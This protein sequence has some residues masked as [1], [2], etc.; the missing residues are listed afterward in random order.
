MLLTHPLP[1]TRISEARARAGSYGAR[2]L[3]PSLDFWLA[4]VRIQVRYGTETPQAL[5]TYFDS[6]LQ[7]GVGLVGAL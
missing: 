2:A 5:L 6:R 3:P 7:K 1:E 4:K